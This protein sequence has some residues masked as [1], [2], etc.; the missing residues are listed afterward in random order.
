MSRTVNA[1]KFKVRGITAESHPGADWIAVS[2]ETALPARFTIRAS[3]E[4]PDCFVTLSAAIGPECDV[5]VKSATVEVCESGPADLTSTTL[6]GVLVHEITQLAIV[7]IERPLSELNGAAVR[8][9]LSAKLLKPRQPRR[10]TTEK[11]QES[12]R[13]FR[14]AVAAGSNGPG[15]YVADHLGV[16]ESQASRYLRDARAGG[17]LDG[18]V[19]TARIEQQMRDGKVQ[20]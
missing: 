5:I 6:R 20:P 9:L 1:E 4:A 14:E 19:L 15:K 16:S 13:L 10:T 3:L 18:H 7:Q 11:I 8:S 2:L 12:A 17:L